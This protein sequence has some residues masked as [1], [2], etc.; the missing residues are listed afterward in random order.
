MDPKRQR[1]K[2]RK[3]SLEF[4]R[5]AVNRMNVCACITD[6]ARELDL[7]PKQLYKWRRA[8]EGPPEAKYKNE[9]GNAKPSTEFQLFQENQKLKATLA[10]KV[11]ELDFFRSALRRVEAATKT[12]SGSGGPAFMPKFG[13]ERGSKAD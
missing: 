7:E 5:D 1:R 12:S 6:L 10:D 9:E 8:I 4:K 11:M 3:L 13:A 2:P